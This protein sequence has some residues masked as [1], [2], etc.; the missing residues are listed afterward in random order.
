MELKNG[1]TPGTPTK[2]GCYWI[3]LEDQGGYPFMELVKVQSEYIYA[4]GWSKSFKLKEI[5]NCAAHRRIEY[6][7]LFG[8]KE[9]ESALK[10]SLPNH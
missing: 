2:D 9:Y 5:W 4:T 3:V 8:D 10:G 7:P 6:P 1:W